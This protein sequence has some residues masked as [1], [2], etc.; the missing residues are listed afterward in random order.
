M[1]AIDKKVWLEL[2]ETRGTSEMFT[3][4]DGFSEVESLTQTRF[5]WR[6]H[7]IA[8]KIDHTTVSK[9]ELKDQEL[10]DVTISSAGFDISI[11]APFKSRE[12]AIRNALEFTKRNKLEVDG[13][14]E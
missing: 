8:S 13:Y 4:K 14:V 10:Y 6:L 9:D 1:I 3:N 2:K 11:I 5:Q 12:A 7:G